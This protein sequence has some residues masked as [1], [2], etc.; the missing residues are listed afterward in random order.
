MLSQLPIT[1]DMLARAAAIIVDGLDVAAAAP[2][3]TEGAVME[4][5]SSLGPDM[6][7]GMDTGGTLKKEKPITVQVLKVRDYDVFNFACV[8]LAPPAAPKQS[9]PEA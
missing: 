4:L 1:S 7:S 5:F 8:Y 3:L 9:Q 6:L 2:V